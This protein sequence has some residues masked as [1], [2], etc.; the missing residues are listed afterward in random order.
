MRL[1]IPTFAAA[2]AA[3][4][5]VPDRVWA[6]AQPEPYRYD[7]GPHMMWWDGGYGMM[8]F[9]P[10]FMMLMLAV[11]IVAVF[12]LVRW[13]GGPLHGTTPP[14]QASSDQAALNILNERFA[15]G[16]IN[17]DEYEEKR[18]LISQR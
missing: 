1:R 9:G 14:H 18:R 5:L 17:K 8:I 12:I 11:V 16:E 2:G 6:Q 15:R 13:F 10:F 4:A 3:A 7:Y